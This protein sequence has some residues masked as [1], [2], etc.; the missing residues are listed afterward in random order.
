MEINIL[1]TQFQQEQSFKLINKKRK[2]K[3]IA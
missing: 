2:E 3:K 1:K